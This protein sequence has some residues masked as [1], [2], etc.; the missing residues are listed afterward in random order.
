MKSHLNPPLLLLLVPSSFFFCSSPSNI[1]Y[2]EILST[3]C[4]HFLA[5]TTVLV[6]DE[7]QQVEQVGY[8]Y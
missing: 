6:V 2:A 7:V 1:Y 8:Y 5:N 4:Q 3:P